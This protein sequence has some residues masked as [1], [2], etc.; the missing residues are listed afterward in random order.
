MV[1]DGPPITSNHPT[2]S[3]SHAC[4]RKSKWR[5]L[6]HVKQL[7]A[8]MDRGDGKIDY[9]AFADQLHERDQQVVDM[10]KLEGTDNSDK[11]HYGKGGFQP[12]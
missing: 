5:A 12:H 4:H 6:E 2:N 3:T 10:Y 7:A 9:S 1:T 8:Q 11:V